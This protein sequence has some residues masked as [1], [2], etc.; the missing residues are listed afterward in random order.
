MKNIFCES[1]TIIYNRA[2]TPYLYKYGYIYAGCQKHIRNFD[3]VGDLE[4]Y[5]SSLTHQLEEN[6]L[7]KYGYVDEFGVWYS[8]FLKVPCR[9]CLLCRY[10][11]STTIAQRVE[12]EANHN[13]IVPLFAT[14][15]YKPKIYTD[16]VDVCKRDVQL[17]KKRFQTFFRRLGFKNKIK[18]V[19]VIERGTKNK[20]LHHHLIIL[21]L[22][23]LYM[24][25][26]LN[27]SVE[28]LIRYLLVHYLWRQNK[29]V[30]CLGFQKYLNEHINDIDNI[31][32]N[33]KLS[34]GICHIRKLDNSKN[35]S[36]YIST[37]ISASRVYCSQNLGVSFAQRLFSVS[38]KNEIEYFDVISCSAKKASF[39]K[40]YIDKLLPTVSRVFYPVKFMRK[41]RHYQHNISLL[42]SAP[43]SM[44]K[45]YLRRYIMQWENIKYVYNHIPL[46]IIKLPIN[47]DF[48]ASFK[49]NRIF[50]ELNE[51]YDSIMHTNYTLQYQ[52]DNIVIYREKRDKYLATEER[53]IFTDLQKSN[54]INQLKQ[55]KKYL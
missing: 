5:F 1:P 6:E 24:L 48:F 2:C 21:N 30:K 53:E 43:I 3:D 28:P 52:A 37:Y 23:N 4:R 18:F 8:L 13:Q 10:S 19:N 15:T 38:T 14:L 22:P 33:D 51:C 49:L 54:L 36:K 39:T 26:N 45:K 44:V 29:C 27:I 55:L 50:A 17:F 9:H 7:D 32:K 31:S 35:A 41:I 16:N 11:Y 20:R 12:F 47:K 40:Y 42:L 34:R 25:Y 46:Q